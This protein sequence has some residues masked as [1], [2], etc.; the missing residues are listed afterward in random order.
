MDSISGLIT[1]SQQH[2]MATVDEQL[3]DKFTQVRVRSIEFFDKQA[4]AVYFYDLTK[5][6]DKLESEKRAIESQNRS[7]YSVMNYFET[8]I[9]DEFRIPLS[10]ILMLLEGLLSQQLNTAMTDI[11]MIAISQINLLLCQTNE[12]LDHRLIDL[13]NFV[14]KIE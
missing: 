13:N 11:I 2:Q 14:P 1:Q 12:I 7:H 10:S 3:I 6:I 8:I 5:V 4:T 9:S